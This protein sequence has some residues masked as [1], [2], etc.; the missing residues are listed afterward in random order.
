MAYFMYLYVF[1]SDGRIEKLKVKRFSDL[2]QTKSAYY[3]YETPN[4]DWGHGKTIPRA[5]I[6][7][8]ELS[9]WPLYDWDKEIEK[10]QNNIINKEEECN[11]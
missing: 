1:Y 7:C 10:K 3:Y 5:D 8:F 4:H 11:K 6:S 2:S 9:P